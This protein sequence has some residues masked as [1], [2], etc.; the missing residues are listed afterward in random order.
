VEPVVVN[1][2]IASKYADVKESNVPDS[3]Y[4]IAPKKA[5]ITQLRVTT[6][7]A[8]LCLS[9]SLWYLLVRRK[10]MAPDRRV[11]RKDM[12]RDNISSLPYKRETITG[13][14]IKKDKKMS[15]L[16]IIF[17]INLKFISYAYIK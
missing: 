2:A 17:S 16:A 9:S 13:N 5:T 14:I 6:I 3:I 11:I 12:P 7:K 10:R 15:T 1:P 4:G 8:S